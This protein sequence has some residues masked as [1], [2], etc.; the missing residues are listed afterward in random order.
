MTEIYTGTKFKTRF[1]EEVIPYHQD[2]GKLKQWGKRFFD[3]GLAPTSDIGGA[4]NLSFRTNNGFIITATSA[5][6]GDLQKEDFV[7][8]ISADRDHREIVCK[9]VREPSSESFI[10]DA[11]Y[12]KRTDV[13]A[14]FHAHAD[15]VLFHARELSVPVTKREQ[16][17]GTI[18][19]MDEVINILGNHL[20]ILIRNHGFLALGS[21]MDQAG[22]EA[23]RQHEQALELIG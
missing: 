11:V 18:S 8:V 3:L 7:E 10:H 9:G 12:R 17:Y 1:V 22:E 15:F 19:L 20:Y 4:G 14:V 13:R 6:L 2:M 23:L 21:S 5:D 16:P